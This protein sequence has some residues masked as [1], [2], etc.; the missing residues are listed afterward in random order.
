IATP[1]AAIRVGLVASPAYLAEHP[2]PSHPRDLAGH[3]LL[4]PPAW[5]GGIALRL[6]LRGRPSEAVEVGLQGH[7]L[8]HDTEV[9]REAARAGGGIAMVLH[10][11][12]V[13]EGLVP[14]LPDWEPVGRGHL[15]LLRP[16]GPASPKVQAFVDHMRAE[17]GAGGVANSR[18]P[19]A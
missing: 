1:L 9:L 2:A 16:A 13:D 11:P 3:R 10:G 18:L 17:F 19:V 5:G 7:L 6:Q 4:L 15:V 12:V 14:V 8:S